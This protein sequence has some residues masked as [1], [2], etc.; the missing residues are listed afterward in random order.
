MPRPVE[1]S[2]KPKYVQISDDLRARIT[3]AEHA[4]GDYLPSEADLAHMYEVS[5]LT[6]RRALAV[7][8][9]E[10][11][12]VREQGVRARVRQ[13]GERTMMRLQPGDRFLVRPAT[14]EERRRWSLGE[15][16]PVVEV[17]YPDGRPGET[18]P[19]YEVE[20]LIE[21]DDPQA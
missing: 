11:L 12:I 13:A 6:V 1:R 7:L 8:E 5:P 10:R 16:E 2:W 14:P 3:S 20:F 15:G 18:V 4:A 19:A 21:P 9:S 17:A